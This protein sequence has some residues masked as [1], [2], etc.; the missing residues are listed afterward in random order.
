MMEVELTD[1]LARFGRGRAV[2]WEHRA[3]A[4][5]AGI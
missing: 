4:W 1:S 2:Y 5:Y 3:Y